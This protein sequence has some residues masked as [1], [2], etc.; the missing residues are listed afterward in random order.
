MKTT[1]FRKTVDDL[2]PELLHRIGQRRLGDIGAGTERAHLLHG[3]I[4]EAVPAHQILALVRIH[5]VGRV[6]KVAARSPRH[7]CGGAQRTNQQRI[8]SEC[9]LEDR[10]TRS[11]M[12]ICAGEIRIEV[13]TSAQRHEKVEQRPGENDDVVDVHPAGHNCRRIADAWQQK[14]ERLCYDTNAMCDIAASVQVI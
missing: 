13:L 8:K 3:A 5:A 9:Q 14:R 7:V 2:L 10:S 4:H 12:G 11:Q 1:V 6:P